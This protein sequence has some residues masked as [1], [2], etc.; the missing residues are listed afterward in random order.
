MKIR[1]LEN[2]AKDAQLTEA[3]QAQVIEICR[4][5]RM[6]PHKIAHLMQATFSNIEHQAIE[7]VTD[8]IMPWCTRWEQAVSR[9]LIV[10][11]DTYVAEFLL[12]ALL[13]GDVASRYSA[14]AIGRQWGWLSI[15]DVRGFENLNPIE[16]G[17]EYLE[18]LN[19]VPIGTDR[20]AVQPGAKPGRCSWPGAGGDCERD[21]RALR[22][23]GR[24]DCEAE[25]RELDARRRNRPRTRRGSSSWART[26]TNPRGST[27]RRR[28]RRSP[29]GFPA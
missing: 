18:P 14:Y 5:Y 3:R 9:D 26:S 19:M 10:E 12:M 6:P 21:A 16:G 4:F 17:D 1:R 15:N 2:N 22:R 28:S 24:A 29:Q 8:T 23:R 11:P 27:S 13:R 20:A 25:T 7:F